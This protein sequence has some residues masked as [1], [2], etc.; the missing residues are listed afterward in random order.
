VVVPAGASGVDLVMSD[1]VR[2]R[3]QRIYPP[4]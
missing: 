4:R 3:H 1:G 2:S